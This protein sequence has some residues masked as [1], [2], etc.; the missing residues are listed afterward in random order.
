MVQKIAVYFIFLLL[1]ISFSSALLDETQ[2]NV[3][4]NTGLT[5]IYP[6]FDFVKINQP[7]NLTIQ[8]HNISTGLNVTTASCQLQIKNQTGSIVLHQNLT[9]VPQG[10]NLNILAENFSQKGIYSFYI[11]CSAAGIGGFTD[12]VFQVNNV[13]QELTEANSLMYLGFLS[14]LIFVFFINIGGISLLPATNTKDDEGRIIAVSNM[15]YLRPVLYLTGWFIFIAILFVASNIGFGFFYEEL[16]PNLFFTLFRICLAI[17]PVII[18]VWGAYIIASIIDDRRLAQL[19]KRG[20]VN[21]EN[22]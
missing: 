5:I 3:N 18:F 12:G 9:A 6:K 14:V 22:F 15:K 4:T 16:A 13:G 1:C 8:V 21:K 10:Y 20:F 11:P 17:S 19:L 7:F 2:S